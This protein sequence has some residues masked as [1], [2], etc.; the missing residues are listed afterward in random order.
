MTELLQPVIE[1]LI[2]IPGMLLAYLPMKQNLR[3]RPG[4]LAA[5][6]VPFILLL[7]LGGGLLWHSL[8]VKAKWIYL[9]AAAIAGLVY[10]RTLQISLWKSVSVFLAVCGVFS[11]LGSLAKIL[12]F[13]LRPE[14][15]APWIS[16][17]AGLLYNLFCWAFVFLAW[18]PATHAARRLQEDDAFAQTSFDIWI[19]PI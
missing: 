14:N 11:C 15:T 8:P 17:E 18:Y 2:F 3:L 19:L 5:A 7:C 10:I 6:M 13:I 12:D 9:P 1:L 4:R 16:T